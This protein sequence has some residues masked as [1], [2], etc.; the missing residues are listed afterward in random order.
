SPGEEGPFKCPTCKRMYRTRE[1]FESHV[2]DC[3]FE[4]STSD[5]DEKPTIK[6]LRSSERFRA[7]NREK[8]DHSLVVDRSEKSLSSASAPASPPLNVPLSIIITDEY[9]DEKLS[10]SSR[11]LS[12]DCSSVQSQDS[13]RSSLRKSTVTQ[14]NA[15]PAHL[16]KVRRR[17]SKSTLSPDES[18]CSSLLSPKCYTRHAEEKPSPKETMLEAVG[19]VSRRSLELSPHSDI[20]PVGQ[21]KLQPRISPPVMDEAP[22]REKRS[23]AQASGN[24]RPSIM[25]GGLPKQGSSKQ[26]SIA[27][28][29]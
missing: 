21:M 26:R 29:Y 27:I 6:E 15:A 12:D 22:K 25:A 8:Y 24:I 2:R 3:D 20:D 14:R 19:L 7:A 9:K 5:E 17:D 28:T 13:R 23:P 1:R 18:T 10:P 16:A 11:D 4:V